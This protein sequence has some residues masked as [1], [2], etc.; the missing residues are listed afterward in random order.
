MKYF[1][2]T[3]AIIFV[4]VSLVFLGNAI[5]GRSILETSCCIGGP[6]CSVDYLC[7]YNSANYSEKMS[8]YFAAFSIVLLI[9]A[10][11]LIKDQF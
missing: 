3:L 9:S 7:K 10:F 6:E 5:T 1:Q 2:I 8:I 11:V 4:V